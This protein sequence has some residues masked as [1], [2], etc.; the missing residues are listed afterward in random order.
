MHRS[1]SRLSTKRSVHDELS[2][3]AAEKYRQ[4]I[5]KLGDVFKDI[6][7][8]Q[9]TSDDIKQ[10]H[11]LESKLHRISMKALSLAEVSDPGTSEG[12]G[13][14]RDIEFHQVDYDALEEDD[15]LQRLEALMEEALQHA[16]KNDRHSRHHLFG[17]R[18]FGSRSSAE[19]LK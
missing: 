2:D 3:D 15:S 4:G 17:G 14:L 9:R 5:Q 10:N 6:A 7:R 19:K 8:K 13:F 16:K 12:L 18:K 1:L 11:E